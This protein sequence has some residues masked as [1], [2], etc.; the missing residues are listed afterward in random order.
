MKKQNTKRTTEQRAIDDERVATHRLRGKT[1]RQIAAETGLSKAEVTKTLSRL[2]ADWRTRAEDATDKHVAESVARILNVIDTAWVAYDRSIGTI[3][4]ETRKARK[5]KTDG[6]QSVAE[7]T[8][9]TEE[10]N[11]DAKYLDIVLQCERQLRAL[12]GMDVPAK[13]EITGPGGG[14]IALSWDDPDEPNETEPLPFGD[15]E[16]TGTTD[17]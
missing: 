10:L 16:P 3:R 15:D 7:V 13:T 14:P 8:I 4:K 6:D 12:L 9:H 11:G 1:H 5:G 17:G 2:R